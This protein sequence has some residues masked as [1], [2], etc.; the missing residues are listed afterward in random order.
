M[1]L[2]YQKTANHE[3]T[4]LQ[5]AMVISLWFWSLLLNFISGSLPIYIPEIFQVF[6]VF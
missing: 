5:T 2:C 1:L 3:K 6:T 4:K